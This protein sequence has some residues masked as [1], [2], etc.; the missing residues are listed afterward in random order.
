VK[1]E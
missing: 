1:S